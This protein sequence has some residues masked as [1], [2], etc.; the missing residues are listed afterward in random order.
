MRCLKFADGERTFE[1]DKKHRWY[2]E[3]SLRR[4]QQIAALKRT[5]EEPGSW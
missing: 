5:L 3:L 4:T 2:A 1:I